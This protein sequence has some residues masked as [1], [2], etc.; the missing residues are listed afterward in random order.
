[1]FRSIQASTYSKFKNK[2]GECNNLKFLV[3]NDRDRD[4]LHKTPF[5]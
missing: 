2:P 3:E 1:M 5:P 4:R